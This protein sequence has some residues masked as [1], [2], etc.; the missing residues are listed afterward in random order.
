M[1]RILHVLWSPQSGPICAY[2]NPTLAYA[3]ARTMLG[4]DVAQIEMHFELPQIVREDVESDYNGASRPSSHRS[5]SACR[6]LR[7]SAMERRACIRDTCRSAC[8]PCRLS[9]FSRPHLLRN[10]TLHEH[11]IEDHLVI[12]RRS[13]G[14]LDE[15]RQARLGHARS[16]LVVDLAGHAD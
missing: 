13:H 12:E 7:R 6:H 9:S 5:D 3:H 14:I 16:Q 15:L 1:S 4:V 10:T 8:A 11:A 2:E